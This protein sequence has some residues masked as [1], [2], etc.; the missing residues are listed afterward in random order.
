[1]QLDRM[2]RD[3]AGDRAVDEALVAHFMRRPA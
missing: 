1:V 3:A 2:A